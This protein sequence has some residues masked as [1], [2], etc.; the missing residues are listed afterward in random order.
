MFCGMSRG[1]INWLWTQ[2]A[3]GQILQLEVNHIRDTMRAHAAGLTGTDA[4]KGGLAHVDTGA[5]KKSKKKSKNKKGMASSGMAGAPQPVL[6][7]LVLVGGGHAHV[8]VLKSFGMKPMPGVRLT[9]VTRDVM[10]PYSGM[11]PGHVAG[12]YTKEECHIDL[13]KLARFAKARVVHATACGIEGGKVLLEGGR[14]PVPYDVLSIDIGSAPAMGGAGMGA[15]SASGSASGKQPLTSA[16]AVTPVK[17]IDG[18]SARWDHIR[19]RVLETKTGKTTVAVVGGGAGGTELALSMQAR[20]HKDLAEAGKDIASV[21]VVLLTRGERVLGYHSLAASE[22]FQRILTDRGIKVLTDHGVATVEDGALV[23][24][25]G[26]RIAFDECVWCTQAGAQSWLKSAS[27]LQLDKNGFIMVEETMQSVN[28]PNVFAAGDIAAL[29]DPRPKAGVFA[30][31][32][33]PPLTAN[34]RRALVGEP[35]S[36]FEAFVPQQTFLGIIGTGKVDLAVASK[37]NVAL[38]GAWLWELKDWIDRKWMAGYSHDLPVMEME[39]P[40]TPDVA[41]TAGEDA[42]AVL[43]HAS[44]RCGGC[45][46]KVGATV[47]SNVMNKLKGLVVDRSDV[48]L[49]GLDS[50]DDCA[51]VK[52]TKLATVHT[53]DFFR[54]FIDD[55]Y[56]FGKIAANHALSDC[57]AMCAEAQTALAI[58]VVPF[59]VESKVEDT[60]YQM[61]AGACEM[62]TESNCALVGGHTCEGTELALGFVING[63]VDEGQAVLKGGMKPGDVLI[64]TKA[65]GTGTIFAA[66]M[67]MKAKGGSVAA[68]IESMVRSNRDAALCLQR[69]GATACT[70]VTGFGLLGHL[71]EMIKASGVSAE[72]DLDAI[73]ALPGAVELCESGIFSSL[74]PANLRLKRAVQNEADALRHK[75]YPLLFDPQTAGGLLSSVPAKN[76]AACVAELKK[77][78]YTNTAVVGRVNGI[79]EGNAA[80]AV[81]CMM[82]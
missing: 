70:D 48:V 39:A 46:A 10:T 49:V 44:M 51:V 60:L 74:Q 45:G 77:L 79:R 7:D 21:D 27:P 22:T 12:N 81:T 36:N 73:P 63:A 52:P 17:P 6:K 38:E 64:L 62:L 40:P 23:C 20:F 26:A 72:L 8:F 61:M 54:S 75:M 30:V 2:V 16:G 1:P 76:A 3:L 78:G 11:L 59:S 28:T 50:P 34:I 13:I 25:N 65:V 80:G 33:G 31:R 14:P 41:H 24:S 43:A 4:L 37:G 29:K 82:E 69:R 47:L 57:H 15:G 53:V 56:I 71:V 18:F 32:A 35:A 55:P 68:A 5:A 66:E 58:A 42:L 19:S 67:R 9:L